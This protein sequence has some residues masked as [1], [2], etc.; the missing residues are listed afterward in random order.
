MKRIEGYTKGPWVCRP[1]QESDEAYDVWDKEGN[2]LTTDYAEHKANAELI[3]AAPETYERCVALE[4]E[5]GRMRGQIAEAIAILEDGTR[6]EKMPLVGILKDGLPNAM[7]EYRRNLDSQD[8]ASLPLSTNTFAKNRVE[9]KFMEMWACLPEQKRRQSQIMDAFNAGKKILSAPKMHPQMPGAMDGLDIPMSVDENPS[10]DFVNNHY[11]IAGDDW[12]YWNGI[13]WA[14]VPVGTK[15]NNSACL[16]HSREFTLLEQFDGKNILVKA[17]MKFG[18]GNGKF[19]DAETVI[20]LSS[21][22]LKEAKDQDAYSADA[23]PGNGIFDDLLARSMRARGAENGEEK[24]GCRRWLV[25]TCY[26]GLME[27]PDYWVILEEIEEVVAP[28]AKDACDIY[29]QKHS[30]SYFYAACLGADGVLSRF[31]ERLVAAR[32][33]N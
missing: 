10:W 28:T 13:D 16:T 18:F 20:N 3:A 22:H 2:Y 27:D 25:A 17:M 21:A 11:L 32:Q 7:A 26:G 8:F 30:C 23:L 19:I 15:M 29:N 4:E 24:E 33:P 14:R 31:G 6:Y 9:E 12:G 5:N 1:G